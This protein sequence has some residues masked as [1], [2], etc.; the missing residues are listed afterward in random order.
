MLVGDAAEQRLDV[1]IVPVVATDRHAHATE[2]SHV[3]GGV[4]DVARHGL[5]DVI[6][7]HAAAGDVNSRPGLA[8]CQGNSSADTSTGPRNHGDFVT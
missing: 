2:S 3:V 5:L 1:C 4:V 7:S 8:E 6:A